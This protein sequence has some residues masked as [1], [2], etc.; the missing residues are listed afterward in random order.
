MSNLET[1]LA[2]QNI[3]AARRENPE[4]SRS[5][6][7]TRAARLLVSQGFGQ[8]WSEQVAATAWELIAG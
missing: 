1:Q 4:V 6:A 3:A 2:L 7:E 5:E 8:V